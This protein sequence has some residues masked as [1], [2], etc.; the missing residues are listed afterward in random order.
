MKIISKYKDYYDYLSGIYGVDKKIILDRREGLG[1]PE[2]LQFGST[3]GIVP[4]TLVIAG[5]CYDGCLKDNDHY[6]CDDLKKISKEEPRDRRMRNRKGW[7]FYNNY[8][9]IEG[10]TVNIKTTNSSFDSVDLFITPYKDPFNTNEL[11]NCPIVLVVGEYL[12]DYTRDRII[13]PKL[14]KLKV[15]KYIPA[16]KLYLELSQWLAPKDPEPI[17]LTDNQKIESKGFD[18][19]K[20]FRPKI[21]KK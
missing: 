6:W 2:I 11:M 12:R 7:L 19:K 16:K 8:N 9:L 10:Q 21:K 1:N 20:S 17:I 4:L 14:E 13:Y 15:A 18:K 5:T 3:N